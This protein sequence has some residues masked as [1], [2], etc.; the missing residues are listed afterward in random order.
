MLAE[1]ERPMFC[2]RY[3]DVES[4][5]TVG[6][7]LGV[8]NFAKVVQASCNFAMPQHGLKVGAQVAIKIVKKPP[9]VSTDKVDMLHAEID[10]LRTI[11][12]PNLVRLY[13]VH[14]TAAKLYLVMELCTGGELFDKIVTLGKYTEEDARYFTFKLLNAVLYLH[15]KHIVHRDLK[16]E[17]ILLSSPRPDA[18]LKITDFGLSRITGNAT[19]TDRKEQM[20][21]TRCGTPGYAAPEVLVSE[22]ETGEGGR[23][24]GPACDMW[25]VGTIVYILLCA[26]P[27][28]HGKTDAEMNAKI[29][30]GEFLFPEKYWKH[31]STGAKEFISGCL[32]VDPSRRL[33]AMEAL[34]H[35]WTTDIGVHTNDLF[36]SVE[37]TSTPSSLASPPGSNGLQGFKGR[38]GDLTRERRLA[39]NRELQELLGLPKDEEAFFTIIFMIAI[40]THTEY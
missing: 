19:T 28:F 10:V 36:S 40:L 37:L 35:D 21:H 22:R 4:L 31:I 15:D 1:E 6:R 34:Q 24:Y 16:P 27:P 7:K 11:E 39:P 20:L 14:E 18:E 29:K 38:M 25:A 13:D 3:T 26:S 33:T 12:H 23:N 8:G 5:Y 9:R 17:N 2:E 32:T 30:R